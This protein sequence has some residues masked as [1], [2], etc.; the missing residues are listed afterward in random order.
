MET[1]VNQE[2]TCLPC[3]L[4]FQENER[5][6]GEESGRIRDDSHQ[7][8]LRLMETHQFALTRLKWS[9]AKE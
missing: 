1:S 5:D 9:T 8:G 3:R 4:R 2:S 7:N 6:L